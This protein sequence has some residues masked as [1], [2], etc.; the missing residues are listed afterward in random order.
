MVTMDAHVVQFYRNIFSDLK[1]DREEASELTEF[2][3]GLNPP[4]DKLLWLRSTA[5][6]VG[7]E[8]L[9]E[10]RD[11]NVSL[12]RTINFIVHAIE[13]TC[14]QPKPLENTVALD[15][16]AVTTFYKG[17]FDDL[18]IDQEENA[19]LFAF[20]KETNTPGPSDLVTTRALAFK[21]GCDYL[22]DDKD[23]NVKLLRC[24]NCIV[25]AFE[26]SCLTPKPFE[27]KDES[28]DLGMSLS[29]AVQHLWEL[30]VNRL[31]PEEDY[32]INVGKGKKPFWKEDKAD[33]P[34][35]SYVDPK[36][37]KRPTYSAF[38]ALLDNYSAETGIEEVVTDAER[39]E[40]WNFL[41]CIMETKPMQFCHKYCHARDPDKVPGDRRGMLQRK[42]SVVS[43][44]SS[45]FIT[46]PLSCALQSS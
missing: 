39:R 15:E 40:V 42:L 4:P 26:L 32:T 38:I 28:V 16:E 7:C 31:D 19:S 2:L 10:D 20:F 24:I 29:D 5:F 45:V 12:L 11:A 35:F 36:C 8:F 37:F 6:K 30:D 14:M 23:T 13:Q 17:I 27:L 46:Q 18:S 22:S 9:S 1:V 34:L 41:N 43:M 33:D 44:E 21:V 3:E 25:H